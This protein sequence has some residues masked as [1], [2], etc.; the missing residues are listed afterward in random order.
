MTYST[1]HVR[2]A[3]V[4]FSKDQTMPVTATL[5]HCSASEV[6]VTNDRVLTQEEMRAIA[7]RAAEMLRVKYHVGWLQYNESLNSLV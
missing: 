7:L 1:K 6:Q 4:Q 3:V 2:F 5:K